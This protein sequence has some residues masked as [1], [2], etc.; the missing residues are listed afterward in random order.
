MTDLAFPRPADDTLAGARSIIEVLERRASLRPGA[1]LYLFLSAPGSPAS[2]LT[3]G[4]LD[5]RSLA[6]ATRLAALGLRGERALLLYPAGTAFVEAFF[7]CLRA[8]VI[9][10]PAYPPRPGRTAQRLGAIARDCRARAALAPPVQ[11]ER[12]RAASRGAMPDDLLWVPAGGEEGGQAPEAPAPIPRGPGETAYLQYTSGSTSR[13]KG[14]MV[15]HANVMANSEEIRR[16][17]G[18]GPGS[19]SMSWLP[20]FHDM[21]L[22]DGIV[23]PLY[24][25]FPAVLTDPAAFLQSP[26]SWLE[27]IARH[28]I[29]HSGAPNFAYDLCARRVEADPARF[30]LSCWD[31]AYNGAEP[32]RAET[33]ERFAARF[34]RCGFRRTSFYPAYGLAEATLKVSGGRRGA[35]PTL[36]RVDR[37]ALEQ[38]RAEP[39]E[40]GIDLA[41]CGRPG[42]G[43]RVAIVD[44]GGKRALPDGA[45]GEIWV[46]GPGVAAGYWNDPQAAEGAFGG[47]L[48]DDP[49]R[50]LRTGDLGFF[51]DG[52]LFVAGRAKDLVIVRGRNIHPQ[53]VEAT[54]AAAHPALRPAGGAAFGVEWAGTEQLVVVH[55]V[56]RRAEASHEAILA[57]LRQAIVETHEVDPHAVAL[58]RPASVPRT[59]SG[60]V[61]RA[62][63]RAAWLEGSLPVLAEWR[64]PREGGA[65]SGAGPAPGETSA[66]LASQVAAMVGA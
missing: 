25:G 65:L 47:R 1:D 45:V 24:S 56:E 36:L 35:G 18:H 21:G 50:W 53:D 41:G 27:G 7:A 30:D 60:K 12:A 44:P 55:E 32:V 37:R 15:T 42:P 6:L 4:Q 9:A 57:A 61:R 3:L 5:Q 19:R 51:R 2:S 34:A 62:A 16:G 43:T 39:A 22:I 64:A 26:A 49:S 14:V 54:A 59:T 58:V 48:P 20:H 63:C 33:M 28:R 29:T 40:E 52:E 10:V 66:W 46:A 17:F 38:R 31:V 13:P 23:Q 11:I 8:G